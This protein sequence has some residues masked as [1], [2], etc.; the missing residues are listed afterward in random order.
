MIDVLSFLGYRHTTI[1]L[2]DRLRELLR[3]CS[4]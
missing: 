2:P 1:C 4:I 3:L